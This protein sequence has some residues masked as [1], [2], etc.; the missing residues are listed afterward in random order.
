MLPVQ[1]KLSFEG[2]EGELSPE[3]VEGELSF[4]GEEG[5][6]SFEELSFEGEDQAKLPV[7]GGLSPDSEMDQKP[8]QETVWCMPP[9]PVRGMRATRVQQRSMVELQ[10]AR[11]RGK[12]VYTH[13]APSAPCA[14]RVPALPRCA[15]GTQTREATAPR[16]PHQAPS[17][18][19]YHTPPAP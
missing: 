13:S 6:L 4:E 15:L 14:A 8:R 19:E 17:S 11:T 5:E 9:L 1:G 10:R 16:P 12:D 7:Q 3:G 2:V 18:D